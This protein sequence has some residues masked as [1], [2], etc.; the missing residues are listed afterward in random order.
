MDSYE[1]N[2]NS[3]LEKGENVHYIIKIYGFVQGIGF[4][5]FVYNKAK[6]FEVYGD[7]RNTGGAVVIDCEGKKENIK[8]FILS[9]K[10][11]PPELAKIEKINCTM[12][13]SKFHYKYAFTNCTKCGPRYSIIK[14][15]PYDRNNTTMEKFQ[16]CEKCK[17]EY[18]NSVS[19]RFHAET[20]CCLKC[21]SKL[22][23]LNNNGNEVIFENIIDTVINF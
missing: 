9:I 10:K 19:R 12:V 5:P 20:N 8:K 14:T 2:S 6:E 16:M 7:V 3:E 22:F 13:K 1:L 4:R 23:L 11:N 17:E 21:G 18:E 15:L